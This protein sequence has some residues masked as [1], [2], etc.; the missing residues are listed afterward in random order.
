MKEEMILLL[1]KINNEMKGALVSCEIGEYVEKLLAK[2]IVVG[3]FKYNKLVAFIAYYANDA[4]SYNG[5]LSMLCVDSSLR[6]E[7][8]A[9]ILVEGAQKHLIKKGYSVLSL[10]VLKSNISAISLYE[11]LGFNIVDDR[12]NKF[13]M[14][15]NI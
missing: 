6:K 7:G 2:A 8:I 10:E 3:Y 12:G 4:L 9:T 15:C 14:C 13:F 1:D 5:F 11:K